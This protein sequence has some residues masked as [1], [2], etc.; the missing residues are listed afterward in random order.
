MIIGLDKVFKPVWVY[1]ILQ[2]SK[3]GND[4]VEVKD[5]FL[6]IIEYDGKVAKRKTLTIIKRYYLKIERKGNKYYFRKNYLH[7][8]SL[9]YSF[10][11]MKPILLFVLL[12]NCPIAKFL[13]SKINVLFIDQKIIN[14][15]LLN[16]HAKETYGDRRVVSF[17]VNYYLTILS[18]FDIFNK[19]KDKYSWK[20]K[21]INLPNH[22]LK[23]ILILYAQLKN[24]FEI[25][26]ATF[27]EETQ[28]SLFNLEN[29]ESTLMEYNS[30]DWVYQKRFD[31]KKVIIKNRYINDL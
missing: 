16:E 25:D 3:S 5:E 19:E 24:D 27:Q 12:F 28:L 29:L 21:K 26:I 17:A 8:L 15:K 14:N 30:V 10:E 4:F 7:D 13:Q 20:N 6:D 31:S 9:K 22:I 18:Y 23:E 11:S 1:K 2:L